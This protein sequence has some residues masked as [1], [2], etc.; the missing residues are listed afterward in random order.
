MFTE[1]AWARIA[2]SLDLSGREL[3]VVRRVFDDRTESAIAAD[4]GISAHTVHTYF[5]RLHHKLGVVDR[6][7][8]VLRITRE[9]LALTVADV[10]ALPPLCAHHFTG[11][12]PLYAL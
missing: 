2:R 1:Q 12:C 6:V 8:L 4:L 7:Q 3:Q 10:N 9:F 11:G 5:Y